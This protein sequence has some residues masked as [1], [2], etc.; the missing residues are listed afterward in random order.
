MA[1]S[2]MNTKNITFTREQKNFLD[3]FF[4]TKATEYKEKI[5]DDD[6]EEMTPE[7]LEEMAKAIFN[8]K[9]FIY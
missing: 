8:T 9:G 4:A 5:L 6:N 3:E 2:T 7:A 1:T